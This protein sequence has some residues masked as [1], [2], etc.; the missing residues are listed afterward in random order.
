MKRRDLLKPLTLLAV[1]SLLASCGVSDER[2]DA[3]RSA[4]KKV[5]RAASSEALELI[6]YDLSKE[7]QEIDS[8]ERSM[9]QIESSASEGDKR[10]IELLDAISEARRM[11]N[12]TLSDK[13]KIFYIERLTEKEKK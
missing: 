8:S 2:I 5:R 13:E 3:Y 9:S 6:A 4:A 11:F 10:S 1:M 12:E 7:L